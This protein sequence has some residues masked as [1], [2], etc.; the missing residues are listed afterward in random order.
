VPLSIGSDIGGSIRIP[1]AFNGV[2]GFK[3]TNWRVTQDG[4]R[5]ALPDSFSPFTRLW[6]TIGPFAHSVED[7]KTVFELLLHP[8]INHMDPLVA[9]TSFNNELYEKARS[10]KVKV[11]YCYNLTT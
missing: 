9:P 8:Q 10:G 2:R 6:P 7:L 4:L 5:N 11:G 3:P 1:A